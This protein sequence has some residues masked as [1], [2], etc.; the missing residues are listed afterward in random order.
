MERK[1]VFK[2]SG[3]FKI[4]AFRHHAIWDS[5]E[6][7]SYETVII[8]PRTGYINKY[9]QITTYT[10]TL[11]IQVG[12]NTFMASCEVEPV[13]AQSWFGAMNLN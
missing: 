11:F 2:S 3:F 6:F 13:F 5:L 12:N 1:F 4:P 8:K 9:L 10:A 7:C